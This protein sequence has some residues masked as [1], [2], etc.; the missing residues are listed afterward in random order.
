MKQVCVSAS[1]SIASTVT[2]STNSQTYCISAVSDGHWAHRVGPDGRLTG[3]TGAT[4]D[5]CEGL[6]G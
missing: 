4:T 3:D 2:G 6:S 1:N 5:P